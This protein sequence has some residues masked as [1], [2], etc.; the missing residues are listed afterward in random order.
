MIRWHRC[1]R[2]GIGPR[3]VNLD[4]TRAYLCAECIVSWS[5]REERERAH[6]DRLALLRPGAAPNLPAGRWAGGWGRTA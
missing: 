2:C 5:T 1:V 6:D 4:G 3:H